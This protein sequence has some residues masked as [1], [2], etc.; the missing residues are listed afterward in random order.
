ME[1]SN[2]ERY[3]KGRP[4]T[5]SGSGVLNYVTVAVRDSEKE[6]LD[7][8][9]WRLRTSRASLIR[10]F[11]LHGLKDLDENDEL[12]KLKKPPKR[13]AQVLQDKGLKEKKDAL[14]VA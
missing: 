10:E 8:W 6:R 5:V 9:A 3:R 7:E 14:V 13:R 12:Q 4:R 1:D 2:A 11:L